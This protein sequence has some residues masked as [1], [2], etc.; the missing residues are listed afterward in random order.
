MKSKFTLSH[1]HTYHY[2]LEYRIPKIIFKTKKPFI[3]NYC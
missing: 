2:Y 3:T 1:T